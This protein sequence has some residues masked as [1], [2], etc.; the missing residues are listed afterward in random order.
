MT[1][2]KGWEKAA[3]RMIK[4]HQ[5]LPSQYGLSDCYMIADDMVWAITGERMY[6]T[7]TYTTPA[8]AA[9]LLRQHGFENVEEAFAAKFPT[10]PVAQAQRGD[11]GVTENNGE[12]CGG[13]FTAI[14]F[15]TRDKDKVMFL[16]IDRVKTAF[17]VG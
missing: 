15:M 11:I 14:G 9:K 4:A 7:L 17:K 16:P 6:G 5:E 10:I 8:G 1:R 13:A 2:I 3:S 12:I